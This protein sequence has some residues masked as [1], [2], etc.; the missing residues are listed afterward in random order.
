MQKFILRRKMI[1]TEMAE[2]EAENWDEAKA[3]LHDDSIEFET[4]HDDKL[5]DESIEYIGDS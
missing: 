5:H 2:I 3:M 4:N 1:Y